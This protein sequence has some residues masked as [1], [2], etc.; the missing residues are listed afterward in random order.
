M[1]GF[2]LKGICFNPTIFKGVK[3]RMN[4]NKIA[5]A[6]DFS[7]QSLKAFERAIRIALNHDAT[8]LIVNVVDTK[9]FGSIAAYDLKYAEQL[10]QDSKKELEKLK[11][12]ALAQGV[13]TIETLV[14]EGSAK[15]ILTSLPEIDLIICGETGVNEVEKM[16]LG[17][18]AE[19][20]VRYST[21]DVLVVR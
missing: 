3:N 4:Y 9:S 11:A 19:R 10:V 14:A 1:R 6:I 7:K 18:I 12:E 20:I 15:K 2:R 5:V 16:M 17:S 13:T 21:Y 8:L